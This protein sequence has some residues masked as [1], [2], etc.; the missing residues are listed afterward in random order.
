MTPRTNRRFCF[1]PFN[2]LL[3]IVLVVGASFA[4]SL[5]SP[6]CEPRPEIRK[7]LSELP[8]Y[9][10]DPALTDWQVYQKR[11]AIL[12]SLAAQYPND[13]F[14]QRKYILS[15]T[16]LRGW[17]KVS[18]E[19]ESKAKAEVKARY[20]HN[21]ADPQAEYLY[22]ITLV[23][24]DTPQAI[25]LFD[26]AVQKDPRFVIPHSN[27]AAVYRWGVFLDKEKALS[28]AKAFLDACPADFEGYAP[29]SWIADNDVLTRYAGQLRKILQNRSDEDAIDAYRI[30][31]SM[32]FKAH[33]ASQYETLRKRVGDDVARLRQLNL[34]NSRA[35]YETLEQ[36]YKLANDQKQV[37]WVQDQRSKH[38][39]SAA[40]L[41]NREK[42]FKDHPF[43]ADGAS[44]SVRDA[45]YRDLLAQ[46]T[47]WLK[48][49]PPDAILAHFSVF[50][51]RVRAM[52]HL[53]N[54]SAADLEVAV[55]QKLKFAGENG[56]GS[57][58]STELSPWSGDYEEAA[59]T[60]SKKHVAPERVIDYA[61]KALAIDEVAPKPI[62]D[63]FTK[64]NLN[65]QQ[66]Y[67]KFSQAQLLQYEIGGYLQLKQA[68]KAE[69]LLARMD[70][71]LQEMKSLAADKDDKKEAYAR[72]LADYW[73][74]RAQAAEVRGQKMDA[75]SFYQSALLI[76]LDAKIKPSSDEKD[77]LAED[78]HRLW[79][80]LQGT[81]DAWQLWYGRRA[82][83]LASANALNWE[84]ANQP[85][86]AFELTDLNNHTWNLSSLK[87]K[88]TLI[89]FWA[90]WCGPCREELPRLQKLI[91]H[92]EDRAGVQFISLNMDD[93]P[94]LIQPFMKERELSMTVIPAFSFISDTLKVNGIPQNW[95][96][97][98]QGVVRQKSVGYDS[99]E[100]WMSGMEGA[101]EEV[102]SAPAANPSAGS[103]R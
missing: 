19:E 21:P 87:G 50:G 84:K 56:G 7:A 86:A 29:L 17:D 73:G 5:S 6:V 25:K 81:E 90:T 91:E 2:L 85:L 52:S 1:E 11:L 43:P 70:Q 46:T 15:A 35:W 80:S 59:E 34:E 36:G 54:V 95:I 33:P 88:T 39:A 100:K 58:W 32:E 93:N 57:P 45:Y 9:R 62:D 13:V 47:Q 27:L 101:I 41:P 64:D 44:P 60:L 22:A 49:L 40:D 37:D 98:P 38:F 12:K 10:S 68:D 24:G 42:W 99:T 77:E 53:D 69:P 26:E 30:L 14:V 102:K 51:D 48:Q 94:G 65:A 76:R 79:L 82:N 23:G 61:Q 103:S 97:D 71:Q 89:S 66:F 3:S 83:D 8:E 67:A 63:R 72:R 28:H 55:E 74:L 16:S 78:A 4:Q 92:Y 20:E 75:M 31:W 96:V 18:A